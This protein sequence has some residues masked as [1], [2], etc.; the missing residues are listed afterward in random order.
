MTPESASRRPTRRGGSRRTADERLLGG[1]PRLIMESRRGGLNGGP[2]SRRSKR[3]REFFQRSPSVYALSVR[4]RRYGWGGRKSLVEGRFSQ[5]IC[6]AHP[7]SWRKSYSAEDLGKFVEAAACELTGRQRRRVL[8]EV[9]EPDGDRALARPPVET[10]FQTFGLLVRRR[11]CTSRQGLEGLA[12]VRSV[13]CCPA[14]QQVPSRIDAEPQASQ[15]NG[16]VTDP[17]AVTS[18]PEAASATTA[19]I[20]GDR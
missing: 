6:S 8:I 10:E 5:R 1:A 2:S 12:S 18:V 11:S 3:Y 7:A 14:H 4:A 20:S 16:P 9:L 17:A 13:Q 19:S 15:A